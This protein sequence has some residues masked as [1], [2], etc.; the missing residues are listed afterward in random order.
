LKYLLSCVVLAAAVVGCG[1]APN[2]DNTLTLALETSPNQLDPALAIDVAEGQICSMVFQGLV[3]FSPQGVIV[4]DAAQ[5]WELED[6]GLRYVFHLNPTARFSDGSRVFSK[7][8]VSSFERV[9][10]PDTKS[11]RGWVLDRISGAREFADG[12]VTFVR[13]LSAEDDSTVAIELSEPFRPFLQMLAMPAACIVAPAAVAEPGTKSEGTPALAL[14]GS[15]R[16]ML[17][18]WERGDFLSLTPNP[19][20]GGRKP[21]LDE[22]R[23]R[24]IPEAFTQIAEFESGTLDVLEI[25]QAELERFLDDSSVNDRIQSRPELRVLYLGLNNRRGPLSDARVRRALNMAVD[26]DQLI[27]SLTGGHGIRATGAIPPSLNG[28]RERHAYPYDLSA[29]KRLLAEAGYEDGFPLE[30]WQRDSP[31]GNRLVE[32][33]QGYLAGAGIEVRIVKREWSAFKEAVS[34]GK[35]DAFFLDWW[36]DYPDAENFLFPLFHSSNVGGGG[37]RSFFKN[38]EVDGLIA[39]AQSG[40]G[41]GDVTGIYARVDSLV[42][43]AAPWIYLYFPT[44]FVAVSDAIDGFVFPSLYLGQDFSSV[45]KRSAGS[46]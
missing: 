3:R 33:I 20:Y 8:V 12:T 18:Q 29:A 44:T 36:A 22:V 39:L 27:K 2:S 1:K 41:V 34:Q 42:Y 46:R 30:I 4:P 24:I 6:D 31:E 17:A 32:A 13:G 7:H 40:A 45:H 15:G 10:A 19:H 28:Y 25:P 14:T 23:F 35:V 11:S 9:L 5:S 16:W 38:E 43:D 21:H 26:V 37:N